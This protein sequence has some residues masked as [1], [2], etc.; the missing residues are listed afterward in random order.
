M[1]GGQGSSTY[2]V[3]LAARDVRELAEMLRF[4]VGALAAPWRA[5]WDTE[6][7]EWG[8][9]GAEVRACCIELAERLARISGPAPIFSMTHGERRA[10][11]VALSAI[12]DEPNAV[13]ARRLYARIRMSADGGGARAPE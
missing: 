2:R 4:A 10:A 8:T 7:A 6:G 13:K 11:M 1:A 5:E 9:E 12:T 3:A